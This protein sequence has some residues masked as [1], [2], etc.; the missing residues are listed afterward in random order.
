MTI[1]ARSLTGVMPALVTPIDGDGAVDHRSLG[2]LARFLVEAGVSGVSPTGTT[3]EGAS[4]SLADRLA[5][6]DTVRSI[7]PGE[8]PV[9]PGLFR[10]VV[11]EAADDLTAYA[12]HGASAALVAPPHYYSL[13]WR[14][15]ASFFETLAART[16]LP[17]VLYNIPAFT[18]NALAPTV[19]AGLAGHPM[20]IGMKDSSRDMEYLLQVGDALHDAGIGP[21]KFSVMTG[22]DTMLVASLAAGARGAIVASANVVPELAVGVHRAWLAGDFDQAARLERRLRQVV[23]ACRTGSF[24]AGWKSAVAAAGHCQPWLVTP[25]HRLDPDE[26]RNLAARLA[27]LGVGS[28]PAEG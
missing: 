21:D 24:P 9:V 4:L 28:F 7:V 2:G 10:N 17:I 11:G 3:G 15:V 20:V 22:T 8:L 12:E 6:L 26:S 5:V 14:D 23:A 19:V 13:D 1:D 18:K 25:R 27:A 16:S